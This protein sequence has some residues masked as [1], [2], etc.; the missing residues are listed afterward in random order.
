MK[1]DQKSLADYGP[2]GHKQSETTD[3]TEHVHTQRPCGWSSITLNLQMRNWDL[4][5]WRNLPKITVL[6]TGSPRK[7]ILPP[8]GHLAMSRGILS[9]NNWAGGNW[10]LR[11][12]GQGYC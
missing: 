11:R 8:Q 3:T 10:Y 5:K 1:E 12:K 7:G 9:C 4:E 6:H 2:Q